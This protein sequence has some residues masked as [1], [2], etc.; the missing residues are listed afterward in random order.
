MKHSGRLVHFHWDVH[1]LARHGIAAV[2]NAAQYTKRKSYFETT[3]DLPIYDTF[4]LGVWLRIGRV[5]E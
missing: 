4:P 5:L 1:L 3:E 2:P